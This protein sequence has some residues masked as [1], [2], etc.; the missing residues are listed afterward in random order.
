MLL[1][2]AAHVS[3][4]SLPVV[5]VSSPVKF[6]ILLNFEKSCIVEA[7]VTLFNFSLTITW[8]C[9]PVTSVNT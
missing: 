8:S 3:L 1:P 4:L 6:L 9:L 5:D 2:S 7:P